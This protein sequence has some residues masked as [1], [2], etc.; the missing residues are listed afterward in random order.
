METRKKTVCTKT[1]L[2]FFGCRDGCCEVSWAWVVSLTSD[3]RADEVGDGVEE[4]DHAKC[5]GQVWC[6][7]HVRRHHG[8]QSH[9]GTVEVS[10]ED[11]EGHK[12]REG[13][14]QR[15][16]ETTETLHP[17]REDIARQTVRLQ[18]P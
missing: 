11:G 13:A 16:E 6:S 15:H 3:G 18:A 8:D 2:L 12:E 4:V 5:R 17:N 10:V 7:H 14:K 1:L 9:V